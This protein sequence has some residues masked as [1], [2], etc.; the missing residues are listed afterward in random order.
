[1]K[2]SHLSRRVRVVRFAV[3]LQ[4]FGDGGERLASSAFDIPKIGEVIANVPKFL[5]GRVVGAIWMNICGT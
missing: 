1:M 5:P 3:L 2:G 4:G